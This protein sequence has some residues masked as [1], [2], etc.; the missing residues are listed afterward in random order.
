MAE[1]KKYYWLKL[2]DDFF[3]SR[4]MKKL[5]KIAGGDIY[6]IIYLK[7]QLLSINNKGIIEFEGT[8]EDIYHQLA[9]DIDEEI[10]DIK[11]TIAFCTTN[12]LIEF[13]NDD[14]FLSE[15]P[16]LI[17]SESSS[18]KRVR[19]HRK[20][21][22]ALQCNGQALQCNTD[23]TKCNTEIDIDIDKDIEIDKDKDIDIDTD[24][25][26]NG[27]DDFKKQIEKDV[28][29][30]NT[31]KKDNLQKIID[32]WNNL[33]VNIPKVQVINSN[34]Q[35]YQML[36]AR[37]N[38]NGL[39]TVLQGIDKIKESKFLKGYVSDFRITI[40]WFIK[41][42]NFIKVLEGNYSDKVSEQ[43]EYINKFTEGLNW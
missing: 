23:V 26:I 11:M 36:K 13:V 2:K 32:K 38:E 16:A 14:V 1:N 35:R 18:A 7:L 33:D 17:G 30:T 25:E 41:P 6:T 9:L 24:I 31:L 19:E 3:K 12:D 8:D 5:R 40:D 43:E 42:N 15:V 22:K 21:Q 4:K 27:D 20:R 39:E 29:N 34:T 28:S 37:I 10:D